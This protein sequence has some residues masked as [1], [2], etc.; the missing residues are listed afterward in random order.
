MKAE[1]YQAIIDT[2]DSEIILET[3]DGT[4]LTL[5]V[6]EETRKRIVHLT[7][8]QTLELIGALEVWM[9]EEWN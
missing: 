8:R 9:R 4:Y 1:Y 3:E 7:R 6:G 5:M 2:V